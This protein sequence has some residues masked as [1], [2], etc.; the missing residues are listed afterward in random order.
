MESEY[1]RLL[2]KIMETGVCKKDRTGVGTLSLFAQQMRFDL[3]KGFPLITTKKMATK[4]VLTELLW[5]LSGSTNV[6]PLQAAGNTI[7]DEWANAADGELGPI[8]GHQ[9]RHWNGEVR[10]AMQEGIPA[11][12]RDQIAQII[13]QIKDAPDSRRH[14][15]TAWNPDDVP[16]CALPPCHILFQFYVE[17]GRL[18]CALTQRS[19]DMFLGIPFNIASYSF[20]THMIAHVCGL[21]VGEFV[22]TINDAHIYMNHVDQVQLQLTRNPYPAPTLRINASVLSIDDF[23]FEDFVLEG[24][25]HHDAIKAPVAV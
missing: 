22:H 5:M 19:G 20:L 2:Q 25:K 4:S 16:N 9:W 3:T 14:V 10:T 21:G 15:V 8:Y 17:N 7:W 13:Q 1:L 23:K 18:S 11:R 12:G 6:R 24:Y